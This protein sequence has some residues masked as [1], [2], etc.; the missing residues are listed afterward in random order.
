MNMK[1]KLIIAL[2]IVLT[3]SLFGCSDGYVITGTMYEFNFN[4]FEQIVE[5]DADTKK[6]RIEGNVSTPISYL[7]QVVFLDTV[8]TTARHKVHFINVVGSTQGSV[9]GFV[10]EST[11]VYLDVEIIPENIT[12]EVVICYTLLY[13]DYGNPSSK[14]TPEEINTHKVILRPKVQKI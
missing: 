4:T 6:I 13:N 11:K 9:E 2:I 8:K 7:T 3:S 12:E 1:G 5:V 14:N 10:V